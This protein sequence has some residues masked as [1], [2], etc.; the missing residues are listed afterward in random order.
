MFIYICPVEK[1]GDGGAIWISVCVTFSARFY[2]NPSSERLKRIRITLEKK[3]E[4][5]SPSVIDK[6]LLPLHGRCQKDLFFFL[7]SQ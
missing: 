5:P 7:T 1:V 3:K 4:N 6:K 2:T